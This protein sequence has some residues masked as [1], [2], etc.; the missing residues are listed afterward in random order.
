MAKHFSDAINEIMPLVK[1]GSDLPFAITREDGKW[2]INYFSL[3]TTA[4]KEEIKAQAA[5][6]LALLREKDPHTAS[7]TGA[8]FSSGSFPFV[9]DRI[10]CARLRA[11]YYAIKYGELNEGELQALINA[12]EDNIGSF[13]QK[14]I[15]YL[16]ESDKPLRKLYELN[17]IPL[18]N[19]G[20]DSNETYIQDNAEEFIKAVELK[21]GELIKE[22]EKSA[23]T[24]RGGERNNA[25]CQSASSGVKADDNGVSRVISSL[26]L[27]GVK[28]ELGENTAQEL[29][30]YVECNRDGVNLFSIRTEDY[31]EALKTYSG[32]IGDRA[33]DVYI[34]RTDKAVT[35]GVEYV[36]LTDENCLPD[37]KNTDFTGKLII[38][39]PNTLNPEYRSSASQLAECTHGNGARPDAIG[40]SV[41]CKELYTGETVVY[42]RHQILGVADEEKLPKWAKIKLETLRDPAA[43]EFRG[44]HFKPYRNFRYGEVDRQLDTDSRPW[45]T[46][47]AYCFGNMK[48]D[49]QMR[50][51]KSENLHTEFYGAAQSNSA[52]IFTCLENGKLYTPGS[53]ELLLYN[54]PSEKELRA[55][56]NKA[57]KEYGNVI[58]KA[59]S[60]GVEQGSVP[61]TLEVLDARFG[62][63]LTDKLLATVALTSLKG[64]GRISN[65]RR[66]WA[67][68]VIGGSENLKTIYVK[69]H[70]ARFDNLMMYA[71]QR[72]T[73]EQT[74]QE[75]E[76][77]APKVEKP[78]FLGK[79]NENKQKVERD[80]MENADAPVKKKKINRD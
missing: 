35:L 49:P 20:G 77:T 26:L 78:D 42:G 48:S 67:Q 50:T 66:E 54:E 7:H 75:R 4:A 63:E 9:H 56:E 72:E 70:P 32:Q 61:R 47:A 1:S 44:F 30:F 64:D 46:D 25:D 74:K 41:F 37:S 69:S 2:N 52:D 38:V 43:F 22:A 6:Y 10:F 80:K 19:R 11:E 62:K 55:A 28:I 40:T 39:D 27:N 12:V 51:L 16:L 18:Y 3:N 23:V 33:N 58:D 8:D 60:A 31:A 57:L 45:R 13:S 15:D 76:N 29:P 59:I 73:Q 79:I 14:A 17:P 36:K 71:K 24:E 5:S 68:S 65:S 34:D 53:V 21:I